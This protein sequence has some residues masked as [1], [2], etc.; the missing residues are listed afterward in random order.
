MKGVVLSSERY[1][2]TVRAE[3]CASHALCLP[4]GSMEPLHGHNWPVEV[5]VGSTGLDQMQAVMDFHVLQDGLSEIL[6]PWQ[7]SH[8]NDLEPFSDGS[9][10]PTAERVAWWIGAEVAKRLPAGVNLLWVRV[11]EATG[12]SAVYRP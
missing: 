8:L 12:C 10:N 7:N 5:C 2:I 9:I 4:D 3:F 1:E 6:K 11:G